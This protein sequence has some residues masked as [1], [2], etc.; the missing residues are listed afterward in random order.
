MNGALPGPRLWHAHLALA[1]AARGEGIA[2]ANPFLLGEELSSGRLVRLEVGRAAVL[3][4]YKFFCRKDCWRS[5]GMTDFRHWLMDL[6]RAS[7]A[8]AGV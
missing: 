4:A 1:A 6:G 3:G 2:L 8:V 7:R 5:P